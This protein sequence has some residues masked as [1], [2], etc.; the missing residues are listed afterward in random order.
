MVVFVLDIMPIL[1]LWPA[2]NGNGCSIS[3]RIHANLYLTLIHDSVRIA[4]H[5]GAILLSQ[6]SFEL[7]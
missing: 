5:A 2:G 1:A 6:M 3:L 4:P 7:V